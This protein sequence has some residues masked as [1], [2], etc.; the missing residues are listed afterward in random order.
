MCLD[1]LLVLDKRVNVILLVFNV[2]GEQVGCYDKI[3]LFDVLV[4][5]NQGEYK[6]FCVIELGNVLLVVD[7]LLGKLGLMVCYDLWFVGLY[8]VLSEKGCDVFIIFLVFIVCI[9]S[10][11]WE[12]LVWVWVIEN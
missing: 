8:S 7:F 11:Y 4:Q 5:D 1:G 10:V 2:V 6:E 9:G 12:M 3:Y